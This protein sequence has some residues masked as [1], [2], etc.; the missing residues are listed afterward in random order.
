MR[1]L[2]AVAV[3][4]VLTLALSGCADSA[5]EAT[6]SL[7]MPAELPGSPQPDPSE[8]QAPERRLAQGAESERAEM[9]DCL[10]VA[11]GVSSVLLAPLSFMGDE[12]PETMTRL[13]DQLHYLHGKVPE[14]LKPHFARVADAAESGPEGAGQF[15]ESAFREALK[16][17]QEWLELHCSEPVR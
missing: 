8:S 4:G 15:D 7:S 3:S 9:K 17:V 5:P 1:P 13:E 10:V 16:P 12:D 14:E 2:F 11:A 6:S